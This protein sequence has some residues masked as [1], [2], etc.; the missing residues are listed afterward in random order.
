MKRLLTLLAT[1]L[2]CHCT[3][4][5]QDA[6]QPAAAPQSTDVSGAD[7]ILMPLVPFPADQANALARRLSADV[8]CVVKV[9][10]PLPVSADMFDLGS[11]QLNAGKVLD[12]AQN[13]R[14]SMGAGNVVTL[15]LALQ[16]MNFQGSSWN[17]CFSQ[18]N[19]ASRCSAISSARTQGAFMHQAID[20]AR[21]ATRLFKLAKKAVGIHLKGLQSST[22]KASVMYQPLSLDDLDEMGTAF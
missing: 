16:D 17:Y 11:G 12:A 22:S 2:L 21:D 13:R 15:A 20:P 10:T 19:K 3:A 6:P 4:T 9:G 14:S 18:H 8:G 7:V 1:A 5:Q